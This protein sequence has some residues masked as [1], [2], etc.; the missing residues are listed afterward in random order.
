[1]GDAGRTVLEEKYNPQIMQDKLL[2]MYN[3]FINK[4]LI[5]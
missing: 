4:K 2:K 5:Q 3:D 1:M